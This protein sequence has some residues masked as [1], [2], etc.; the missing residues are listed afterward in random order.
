MGDTVLN[1]TG[2]VEWDGVG[3]VSTFT[4]THDFSVVN[5]H[6]DDTVSVLLPPNIILL[7]GAYR[8]LTAGTS[9]NMAIGVT[10]NTDYVVASGALQTAGAMIAGAD[11]ATQMIL[12]GATN[13]LIF[14][15]DT[16]DAIAGVVK[17]VLVI[18]QF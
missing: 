6:G 17:V 15:P 14:N 3:K 8:V 7:A 10:G 13:Y 16:T 9:L 18:A 1:S 11:I 4:Y 2:S 5:C 12:A